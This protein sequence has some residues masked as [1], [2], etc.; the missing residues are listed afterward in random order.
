MVASWKRVNW[1]TNTTTD[2]TDTYRNIEAV[3]VVSTAGL[4]VIPAIGN[5]IDE[6]KQAEE[7][8][9]HVSGQTSAWVIDMLPSASRVAIPLCSV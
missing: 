6:H 4:K 1:W 8:I 5:L 9:C 2:Q 3:G 7:R